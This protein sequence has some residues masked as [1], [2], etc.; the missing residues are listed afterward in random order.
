VIHSFP[1]LQDLPALGLFKGD[2]LL[3]EIGAADPVSLY[4]PLPANY[5]A[6]L[7][8]VLLDASATRT[9]LS[10]DAVLALSHLT[11]PPVALPEST[12][13]DLAAF[14]ALRDT[15]RALPMERDAA[16]LLADLRP[17]PWQPDPE[18][19]KPFLPEDDEDEDGGAE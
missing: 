18:D 7:L 3:V 2:V 12:R 17:R 4:H 15:T 10:R 11:E 5:Y 16:E 14:I 1:I 13:K 6:A 19:L 9:T 8:P